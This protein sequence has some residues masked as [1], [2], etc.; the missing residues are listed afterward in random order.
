[1]KTPFLLLLSASTCWAQVASEVRVQ[2]RLPDN[3][4]YV[5]RVYLPPAANADGILAFRGSTSLPQYFLIGSGLSF[6]GATSAIEVG[7]ISISNVTGLSTDLAA[8]E[9]TIAAGTSAQYWRGDKTW[10]TFP[11]I[12]SAQ[13][14]S[15]WSAV[16]GISQILNK[17]TLGTASTQNIAAFDAAGLAA[18]AQ[19]ASQPLDGDLTAIAALTT[20][21]F[22]RSLLTQ[23]D[24]A[25]ART[26]IGAGTG[27]GTVTSVAAGTGLAGGTITTTGTIS[28]PNTGT[29]GTYTGVTTD[30]QGRVTAGTTLSFSNAPVRSIVTVAAA[31]NGW[32]I[33]ASQ[34]SFVTYTVTVTC[35]VQI[36]LVTNVEGY[37]AIER[38]ATNST[39]AS[40]WKEVGRVTNGNNIGIALGL[41]MAQK[42]GS[43]LWCG[44]PAGYWVRLR[45][46]NVAGTPTYSYIGGDEVSM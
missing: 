10:Q 20:T 16:S 33:S 7:T 12:P 1:M 23:A 15:D 6:N 44:V 37:V 25:A 26:A 46:V 4:A 27:S 9:P 40:D 14:N 38:S 21:T 17:P 36:G 43:P 13:V 8:K 2:Q 41:S 29:A 42:A 3:S 19:A 18:A 34:N 32:Q 28:L 45:S 30:A 31:A 11:S 35:S 24:A 39:T 22:G 5:N